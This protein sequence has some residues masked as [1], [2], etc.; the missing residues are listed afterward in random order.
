[1][2]NIWAFNLNLNAKLLKEVSIYSEAPYLLTF[3]PFLTLNFIGRGGTQKI[4]HL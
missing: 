2:E 4:K 1:M 3:L